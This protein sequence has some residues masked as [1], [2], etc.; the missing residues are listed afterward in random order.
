MEDVGIF[1]RPLVHFTANWYILL[2]FGIFSG[3]YIGIFSP[4]WYAVQKNLATL[5]S[6]A[7]TAAAG[8]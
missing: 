3:Y 8:A 6:R 5:M 4:S 2:P 7:A 1:Y